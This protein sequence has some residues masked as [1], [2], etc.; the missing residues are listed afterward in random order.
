MCLGLDYW[1]MCNLALLIGDSPRLVFWG[2]RLGAWCMNQFF[3]TVLSQHPDCCHGVT[4]TTRLVAYGIFYFSIVAVLVNYE[5]NL[6]FFYLGHWSTTLLV[7]LPQ[8]HFY[9]FKTFFRSFLRNYRGY[10]DCNLGGKSSHHWHCTRYRQ[11]GELF[12]ENWLYHMLI[13]PR[14][15]PH[16][17]QVYLRYSVTNRVKILFSTNQDRAAANSSPGPGNS[18]AVL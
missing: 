2:S 1:L 11:Y 14:R 8:E 15:I 10:Q 12:D 18:G 7:Y 6:L 9:I 5:L 16:K 17:T 3:P 13:Y 4:T